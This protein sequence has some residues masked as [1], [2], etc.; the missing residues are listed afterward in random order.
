MTTWL[1]ILCLAVAMVVIGSIRD[2]S[3]QTPAAPVVEGNIYSVMYVEVRPTA[4]A[5]AT[6]ELRRYRDA[7]RGENGN[8]RAEL[9]SRIGQPHQ[10]VVLSVWKDPKAHEAHG[11][12]ASAGQMREK[13]Q[14]IR[15]APLDERV[16]VGVSVGPV[17]S[18]AA[19]DAVYVVTHVDVI[20]PRKDDGLAALKL[21]GDAGRAGAGNA[22]FEVVQQTNRANHFSV[23]EIWKDLQAVES[24]AM[25]DAT[26]R[27][28]DAL[29]PIS[30]SLYD[31]RMYKAIE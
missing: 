13:I 19:R 22:R 31:E 7:A 30:G 6:T 8:L 14:T 21:L 20:P 25:S 18:G 23:I 9:V 17:Q 26:R 11:K 12:S 2:V 16:H 5:D 4:R 27:F 3:A 15:V 10:F 1:A 28:R 29:G 24:H